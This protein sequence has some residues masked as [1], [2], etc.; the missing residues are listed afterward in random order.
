MVSN[1]H[2]CCRGVQNWCITSV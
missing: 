2:C 1:D